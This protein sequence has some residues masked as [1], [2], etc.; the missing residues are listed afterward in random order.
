[1]SWL[2]DRF[3]VRIKLGEI[4]ML[5]KLANDAGFQD[6]LYLLCILMHMVFGIVGFIGQIELPQ[7]VITHKFHRPLPAQAA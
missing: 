2:R 7:T 1:M 4:K 3:A 5:L 6:M